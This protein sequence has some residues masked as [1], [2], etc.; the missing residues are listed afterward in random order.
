[1][2]NFEIN[3]QKRTD[4]GKGASRRLRRSGNIPAI[5]YGGD[6][7]P[8]AL[9]ISHNELLKHLEHEAF[10]SHILIVNI[11]NQPERVILKDLQR[12]PYRPVILHMDLQRVSE[13]EKVHMKVP[14]HFI[15][16]E[17]CIGVK[18]GGGVIA[19]QKSD[20][21]IRC[22]PK[23]LPEFIEIDLAKVKLNQIVHVSDLILP[24]GVEL[25]TLTNKGDKHDLPV[26]SIHLARGDK[27]EDDE[28]SE[29][30]S[31]EQE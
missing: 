19:R 10:Y 23:Y 14:L 6:Q 2:E 4:I 13:A 3:A 27:A 17:T 29:E 12:H 8:V 30:Q 20:L 26:V 11:D 15:N 7:K 18:Q 1:M 16:E 21:E 22:L 9:T 28:K 24:E 31:E 5:I 25:V